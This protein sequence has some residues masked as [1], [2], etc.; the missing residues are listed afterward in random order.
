[1]ELV[2]Q[3]RKQSAISVISIRLPWFA[4][5]TL[6]LLT[7]ITI[8]VMGVIVATR[9]EVSNPF[10]DFGELFGDEARQAAV[11]RGFTCQD[12]EL[13]SRLQT[14]SGYC[15]QRDADTMFSGIYMWMSGNVADEISFSL[16]ENALTLGDLMLLWGEPEIQLSCTVVAI[17][18]PAHRIHGFAAPPPNGQI[19][20]FLPIRSVSFTRSGSSQWGQLLLN[21]ARHSCR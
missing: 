3:Y 9:R 10:S 16:R 15:A 12:R 7:S 20:Y 14:L 5:I 1:M 11:A 17:T 19:G 8:I 2:G 18:W 21:D 6:S 13:N 4:W